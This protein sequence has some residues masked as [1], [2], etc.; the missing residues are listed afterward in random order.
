MLEL[1]PTGPCWVS[2]T[3]DGQSV[4]SR[5]MQAGEKDVR[6]IR[7]SAV[8]EVGDAGAFAF[9]INGRP[10]RALGESG[11]VKKMYLS[12]ATLRDYLR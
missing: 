2:V 3:V 6:R 8:I 12:R 4:L 1:H 9:S 10:G 5:L 11:Q 7:D